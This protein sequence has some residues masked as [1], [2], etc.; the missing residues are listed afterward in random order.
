VCVCVFV[1]IC[2]YYYVVCLCVDESVCGVDE[3]VDKH[4]LWL[5]VSVWFKD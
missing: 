2:L 5:M 4:T 1:C 3:C